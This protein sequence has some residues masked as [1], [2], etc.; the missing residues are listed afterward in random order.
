VGGMTPALELVARASSQCRRGVLTP[1]EFA[2][3]LSDLFAGDPAL[4]PEQAGEVAALVPPAARAPV[5]R[6]VEA[7]L[8]PGYVR[9]AFALGGRQRTEAEEAA[10]AV[11][12]TARERAWAE[13]L[14]PLLAG[15]GGRAEPGAAADR[16]GRR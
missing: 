15:L 1:E 6:R 2:A 9:R 14:Q 10:A 11:R 7:A 16:A 4:L 5:L 12:E 8:A 13:A 3:K